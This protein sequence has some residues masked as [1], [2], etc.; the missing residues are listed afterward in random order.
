MGYGISEYTIV[1]RRG[2]R[3]GE[4]AGRTWTVVRPAPHKRRVSYVSSH[5]AHLVATVG[6]AQVFVVPICSALALDGDAYA[7]FLSSS[8][9]LDDAL[10]LLARMQLTNK[11]SVETTRRQIHSLVMAAEVQHIVDGMSA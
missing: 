4:R 9:V 8:G 1:F 3:E 11:R 5:P 10:R 7:A 6:V 2:A